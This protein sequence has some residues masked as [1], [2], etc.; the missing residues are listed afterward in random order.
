ME[1]I[2]EYSGC[3]QRIK[4][5][6][7]SISFLKMK[8]LMQ[9]SLLSKAILLICVC[10]ACH[11]VFAQQEIVHSVGRIISYKKIP[12]GIAGKRPPPSSRS[13]LMMIIS[14]GCGSPKTKHSIISPMPWRPACSPCPEIRKYRTRTAASCCLQKTWSR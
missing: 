13:G 8:S 10:F 4:K 2:H 7:L 3:P 9:A 1:I 12:G 5:T 11:G 14:S 6:R